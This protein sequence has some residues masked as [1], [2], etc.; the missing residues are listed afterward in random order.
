MV[1]MIDYSD[2]WSKGKNSEMENIQ[3]FFFIL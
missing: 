3:H 1:D 2:M